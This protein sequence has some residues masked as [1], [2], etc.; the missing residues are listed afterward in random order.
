[1][2]QVDGVIMGCCGNDIK[3]DGEGLALIQVRL[4]AVLRFFCTV[5]E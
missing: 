4:S 2:G 5:G 3:G 1:M